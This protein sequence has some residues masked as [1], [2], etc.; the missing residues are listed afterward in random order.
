MRVVVE[1]RYLCVEVPEPE[2]PARVQAAVGVWYVDRGREVFP[3]RLRLCR[4]LPVFRSLPVPR[5]CLRKMSKRWG[6]CSAANLLT[7][8]TD[9]I[10]APRSC[11]DYVLTHELCHLLH[12]NHSSDFYRLL[13]S[14]MPDWEKRKLRLE[15]LL[16]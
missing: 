14:V 8:N 6:S 9:L 1:N 10:R 11:I 16:C 5:L 2:N 12:P 15:R 7:I 3:E 4:D 13:S